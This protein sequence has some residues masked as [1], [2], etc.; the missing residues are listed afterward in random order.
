MA[1]AKATLIFGE[2]QAEQSELGIL[3]PDLAAPA[4]GRLHEALALLEAV[5]VAEQPRHA[6][7]EEALLFR[8]IEIHCLTV[9][10]RL[11]P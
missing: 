11:W 3:R 1:A 2:G 4:L 8:Q 10:G 6:V 5:L 9:P 7:L